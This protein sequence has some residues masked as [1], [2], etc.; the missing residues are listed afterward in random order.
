MLRSIRKHALDV[1]I[2][3]LITLVFIKFIFILGDVPTLSMF[4][5]INAGD[6]IGILN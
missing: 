1:T 4:P 3:I 6:Q 5:T 2:G